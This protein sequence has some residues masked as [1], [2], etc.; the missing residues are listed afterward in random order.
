M[1]AAQA[2]A[3]LVEISSQIK[4]VVLFDRKG[5]VVGTTLADPGRAATLA[6]RGEELLSAAGEA[7]PGEGEVAQVEVAL[8]DASV[9][10]VRQDDLA[11]LALSGPEPTSGLVFYDLK[12]CLRSVLAGGTKPV[13]K[14]RRKSAA[15]KANGAQA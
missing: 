15:R 6:G 10:V 4:D 13:R 5:A 7:A 2:L 11:A 1:D 8:L 14:P 3:D 9:F 12:T